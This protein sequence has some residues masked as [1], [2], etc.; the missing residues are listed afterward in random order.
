[1]A[2]EHTMDFTKPH[3]L[4]K[5]AFLL[6]LDKRLLLP[7]IILIGSLLLWIAEL[8]PVSEPY[9][10][11]AD[12]GFKYGLLLFLVVFSIKL[13]ATV[14]EY[15]GYSYQ[16]DEEFFQVNRGYFSRREDAL[17]YH[18]IQNVNIKRGLIYRMLGLSQLIIIMSRSSSNKGE[19]DIVLPALDKHQ[20]KLVQ[21]EIMH[22]A[23]RHFYKQEDEEESAREIKE[24]KATRKENPPEEEDVE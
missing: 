19:I 5:R 10:T 12:Y 18:Q 24:R 2:K 4:G 9:G 1:M 22:R 21:R 23:R 15:L 6:F 8:W 14:F 16:F 11:Y 13:T 20:A 17:A 7:S 3:R